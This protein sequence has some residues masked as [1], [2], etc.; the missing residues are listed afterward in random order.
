MAS[1]KAECD[2]PSSS[3]EEEAPQAA[4]DGNPSGKPQK[5]SGQKEDGE[6]ICDEEMEVMAGFFRHRPYFYD[7]GDKNY[8]SKDKK[9]A[10]LK[11]LGQE[12][13]IERKCLSYCVM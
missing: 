11:L 3:S 5:Q 10:A 8:K 4:V 1:K 7:M 9:E 6:E 13:G 12:M 2:S